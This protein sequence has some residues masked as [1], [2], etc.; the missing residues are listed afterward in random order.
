MARRPSLGRRAALEDAHR[1]IQQL[2]L[3]VVDV[4]RVHPKCT[5]NSAM[6]RSPLIAATATFALIASFKPHASVDLSRIRIVLPGN[7]DGDLYIVADGSGAFAASSHRTGV[8]IGQR[9]LLVGCV[10]NCVSSNLT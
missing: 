7:V 8:G 5:A 1:T 3:P 4:V 6:V 10:L 2:L 9:D